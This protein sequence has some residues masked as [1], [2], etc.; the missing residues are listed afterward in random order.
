M[1]EFLRLIVRGLFMFLFKA[2]AT[3]VVAH[4]IGFFIF[5]DSM[6]FQGFFVVWVILGLMLFAFPE[7]WSKLF[8]SS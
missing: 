8:K 4:F 6:T 5:G 2:A 1:V 7:I 3:A